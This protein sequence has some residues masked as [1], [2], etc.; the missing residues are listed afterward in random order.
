[1]E[2]AKPIQAKVYSKPQLAQAEANRKPVKSRPRPFQFISEP[3]AHSHFRPSVSW[4]FNG[5]FI[6]RTIIAINF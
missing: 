5:T 3:A 1:M 2:R 6:G 4:M